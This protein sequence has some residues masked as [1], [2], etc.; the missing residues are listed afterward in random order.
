[1]AVSV[2]IV[3]TGSIYGGREDPTK[4]FQAL[5]ELIRD[6]E[7]DRE[8]IA[9]DFYGRFEEWLE[10]EIK[11][12]GLVGVAEQ[13]GII[14]PEDSRQ[15]QREAR[16]LWLMKWEDPKEFG[17]IPG[18]LFEYMAARRPIMATG[19]HNDEVSK[20]LA[21]IQMGACCET[22]EEIKDFIRGIY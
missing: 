7:V 15:A 5:A 6:G 11:K 12:Y 10:K 19:G 22:V 21:D 14:S 3:Y 17:V 8:A 16:I 1:M 13:H 18:K 9:V 20:I 4:L 2:N